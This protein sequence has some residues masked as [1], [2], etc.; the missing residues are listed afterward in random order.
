MIKVDLPYYCRAE[1]LMDAVCVQGTRRVRA[2]DTISNG[3]SR[4]FFFV[5]LPGPLE[6]G[7]Q[8]TGLV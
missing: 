1:L 3:N 7:H 4:A 6:C 2:D 8:L 5:F